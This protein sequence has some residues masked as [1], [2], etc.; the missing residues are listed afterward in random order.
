MSD[1]ASSSEFFWSSIFF[2]WKA[3]H[4]RQVWYEE[5]LPGDR[6]LQYYLKPLWR[7]SSASE[8]SPQ[9]R[10]NMNKA[11]HLKAHVAFWCS[12]SHFQDLTR[13]WR[14]KR[15]SHW[16][17]HMWSHMFWEKLIYSR[18]LSIWRRF[19]NW[20]LGICQANWDVKD[21]QRAGTRFEQ[22]LLVG[23]TRIEH[24]FESSQNSDFGRYFRAGK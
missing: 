17:S 15:E 5:D 19:M 22:R 3:S 8:T 11:E 24:L 21:W 4:L 9:S 6:E 12:I 23:E 14:I 7:D 16:K 2:S 20:V 1:Q 18:I 10:S 13:K